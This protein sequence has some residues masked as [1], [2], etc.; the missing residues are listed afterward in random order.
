MKSW[1]YKIRGFFD[2][3]KQEVVKCTRPSWEEL[4]ES[5][6]VIVFTMALI[7]LSIF[8]F[9]LLIGYGMKNLIGQS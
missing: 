4:R 6:T 7:G 8:L 3:V 5:S 2:E 1:I 9:D